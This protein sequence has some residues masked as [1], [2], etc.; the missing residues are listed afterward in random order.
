MAACGWL[1]RR[2]AVGGNR[3]PIDRALPRRRA[4]A[5]VAK[6]ASRDQGRRERHRARDGAEDRQRVADLPA[7]L[8]TSTVSSGSDSARD[9]AAEV[10][11]PG[12]A[13]RCTCGAPTA[14]ARARS[15]SGDASIEKQLDLETLVCTR[16]PNFPLS[17][18]KSRLMC[19]ACESR[20]VTVVFEPPTNREVRSG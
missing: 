14:I 11:P 10:V 17:R 6:R 1:R 16:G 19:P 7:T 20:R 3:Q 13:K 8:V 15:P 4:G 18:L 12:A 5:G 9:G 2:I